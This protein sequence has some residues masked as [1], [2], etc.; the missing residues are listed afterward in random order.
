MRT[1]PPWWSSCGRLALAHMPL[2]RRRR[3]KR[4]HTVHLAE[5]PMP[6]TISCARRHVQCDGFIGHSAV[7]YSATTK[8][9][10]SSTPMPDSHAS[11]SCRGE[12]V[13]LTQV[14]TFSQSRV[15]NY[16]QRVAA[17]SAACTFTAA[18][19]SDRSS[20]GGRGVETPPRLLSGPERAKYAALIGPVVPE[21]MWISSFG[22]PVDVLVESKIS[23][24]SITVIGLA[25][26]AKLAVV[27]ACMHAE[28]CLDALNIPLF[29]SEKRQH[30]RV[31]QAAA[32]GRTAPEIT[33]VPLELSSVQLP[34]GVFLPSATFAEAVR[35][36]GKSQSFQRVHTSLETSR[37]R[38]GGASSTLSTSTRGQRSRSKNGLLSRS[39]RRW[40][41]VE[42]RYG[43]EW[44]IR[45]TLEELASLQSTIF[46]HTRALG[47]EDDE[48]PDEIDNVV[49]SAEEVQIL[50][51]EVVPDRGTGAAAA[52]TGTERSLSCRED[53][54][55]RAVAAPQALA[56]VPRV[57]AASSKSAYAMLDETEG[58]TFDLVEV[59]YECW[60]FE[61]ETPGSRCL[62]DPGAVGRVSRY[63]KRLTGHDFDAS[64]RTRSA[65]EDTNVWQQQPVKVSVVLKTWY[66]MWL[67]IPG[68]PV[69]AVGK[70]TTLTAARDLCAMHAELLLQWFGIHVYET[71]REQ[72]M[73]YDACLRWGRLMAVE[74]IDPATI[75]VKTASLP[76]PLK[77]WFRS[78][79]KLRARRSER[80]VVEKLLHLNRIVVHISR[81]HLVEVNI[82]GVPAYAELLS[83]VCACLRAFMVA[84]RHPYESAIFC[85]IYTKGSQYRATVYLPLPERYGVRGGYSIGSTPEVAILLCALH[86][87]DVLCALDVVPAACMEQQRWQR[88]M[89]LR[90]SLGLILP[91]SYQYKKKL[92]RAS[93]PEAAAALRPPPP[94]PDPRLRSPPAYRDVPLSPITKI[95]P[96]KEVWQVMLIDADVFDVAPD[97]RLLNDEAMRLRLGTLFDLPQTIFEEFAQYA[98][99]GR[100][101][102]SQHPEHIFHYT[103]PQHYRGLS[104][105]FANN[106]WME[107]P[108]DHAVYGRRVALGRCLNRKG[109]ERM[110]YIHA[111]RIVRVLG[112]TPW[113]TLP[114]ST[115][116]K[117]LYSNNLTRATL[118][119]RQWKWVCDV[120][121][122]CNHID[123]A[124]GSSYKE[125]AAVP[126]AE[127]THE[128]VRRAEDLPAAAATDSAPPG[129]ANGGNVG[130][131][132]AD[133]R[134]VL[135]PHP[136]MS[137]DLAAKT[138]I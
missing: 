22:L 94:P 41:A 56:C 99:G 8:A 96:H 11:A 134:H 78:I 97:L 37:D 28:R 49:I 122:E 106:H 74:P 4:L 103:G 7:R 84:V 85:Y 72:A 138:M 66:T 129:S 124:T 123:G 2:L 89:E 91:A 5:V 131:S 121:L 67:D 136:V 15:K 117:E 101:G 87:V 86:A 71:P 118:R 10:I 14:D 6:G 137:R 51:P 116:A 75:D 9:H 76:K 90:E 77:E 112:L 73:Y 69:P 128:F 108:L 105:R 40:Q 47:D 32:E 98:F 61:A 135:S 27:A 68:I 1:Q 36:A 33:A 83:L 115:L 65:E 111:L 39:V 35:V 120:L 127:I 20:G 16:F 54:G 26:E 38:N 30:Q 82:T 13:R 57:L 104:R 31:L 24:Q 81:T 25:M 12:L 62:C 88:M 125:G 70:A 119:C 95:P 110:M 52:V 114:L 126:E 58:G 45:A 18:G 133:L 55:V 3:W 50:Q 100:L 42:P 102:K 43:A 92:E 29:T 19:R 59:D 93:S 17:P 21:N 53:R 44:F 60:W 107:M 63:L 64:V 130:P 80:S 132:A 34:L 46:A 113:D 109:A 23:R 48:D 79:R